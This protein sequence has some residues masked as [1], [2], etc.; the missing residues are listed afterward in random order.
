VFCLLVLFR[1][2][3]GT[4]PFEGARRR[5]ILQDSMMPRFGCANEEIVCNMAKARMG[6]TSSSM[7]LVAFVPAFPTV[8]ARI[9]LT[10]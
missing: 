2:L 4:M 9:Q 7:N 10:D 1:Y 8:Q 5:V 6:T 3:I